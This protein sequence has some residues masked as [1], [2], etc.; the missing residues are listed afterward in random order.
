[1]DRPELKGLPVVF[2]RIREAVA[3]RES[4]ACLAN[5]KTGVPGLE[6]ADSR[7]AV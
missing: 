3:K 1:V 5:G 7:V 4:L 2:K 6:T